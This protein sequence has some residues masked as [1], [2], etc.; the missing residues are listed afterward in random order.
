MTLMRSPALLLCTLLCLSSCAT[1]NDAKAINA[2]CT[3]EME[4]ARTAVLLRDE[5]KTKTAML[6]T[7]PPLTPTSS[8]LLQQLHA[9]VAEVY[10]QPGLNEVIYPTYRFQYCIRQL[11]HQPVPQSLAEI[12]P[13]L[14]S[15]QQT[16]GTLA[17]PESTTCILDSFPRDQH[18]AGQ[19]KPDS[20]L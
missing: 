1:R 14:L 11:Q 5:G 20:T 18:S 16:Y 8:R 15:C 6:Q 19:A 4:A 17:S 2:A 3:L 7:L 13:R 10:T 12:Q 9:I